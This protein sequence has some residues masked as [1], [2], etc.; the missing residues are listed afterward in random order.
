MCG[1][2]AYIGDKQALSILVNGLKRM[3]YRGYDSYG[4]CLFNKKHV[5]SVDQ[6]Q[7]SIIKKVGKISSID[8]KEL[9]SSFQESD[10]GVAHTRWATHGVPSVNNAHPHF[11]MSWKI[12]AVH[13]GIIENY[14]T[15]RHSLE[16][17]GYVF[18]SETDTETLPILVES[19]MKSQ[20]VS[21]P[22]GVALALSQVEGTFG[23]VFMH[24]DY[25]EQI[26]GAR[27]GS[28]LI[29]G[30]GDNEAILA[31]DASAILNVTKEVVYLQDGDM[32]ILNQCGKYDLYKLSEIVNQWKKHQNSV[33]CWNKHSEM[34]RI[35]KTIQELSMDIDDIEKGGYD[36]YML[37]EIM[38]QTDSLQNLLRGRLSTA[39]L[40]LKLG[41]IE[42]VIDVLTEAQRYIIIACG[43]SWHSGLVAKYI[44]EDWLR[45]PVEVD[46]ASEFR[47]R[48]PILHQSD[49]CIFISQSGETADTLAAIHI[50]KEHGVPT[51]GFV[52]VVGSTIARETDAGIYLH[53]GPEIGV[54]STKAF[55]GQVLALML[56]GL[57]VAEMKKSISEERI[58]YYFEQIANLP[59]I[60]EKVLHMNNE[61][62][63]M[64]AQIYRYSP[65]FL[66]L[67]RGVNYPV[68]LEGALKMKEISY[69]HAE[70]YPAAEMKHGP[71]ALIDKQMPVVI[72]A[73]QSDPIYLK[74]KSNIEEVRARKGNLIIITE[75]GNTDFDLISDYI[76]KLPK[77]DSYLFPILSIIPLQLLSYYT[78]KMRGCDID[79]PRNLAKSVTVE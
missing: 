53:V 65:S 8:T 13:N 45:I 62:I 46:Y 34:A 17:Q 76:I 20:S 5:S 41:G 57:K 40:S 55:T 30:V 63:E 73:P 48:N 47:Y 1:I 11:S 49:V 56:L 58:D 43:T 35:Q 54:A 23:V 50:A 77:V 10:C 44:L 51:I 22:E 39:P 18:K 78:A 36:H 14:S 33:D 24:S 2:V 7:F 6:P 71:I 29:L 66:Y 75:E 15:L 26:I 38:E 31:S 69:I 19:I 59:S 42:G 79:Q 60:V 28:P 21:F 67:G 12:C 4:I 25:P 61:K 72:I 9:G 32:V 3:E 27:N 68:A 70:G 37:K 16:S 64:I 74:V 52:N